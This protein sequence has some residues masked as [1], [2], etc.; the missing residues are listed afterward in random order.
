MP[1]CLRAAVIKALRRVLAVSLI[2]V[3]LSLRHD[4]TG[5]YVDLLL[6]LRG[7][8]RYFISVVKSVK[9]SQGCLTALGYFYFSRFDI[10]YTHIA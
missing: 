9:G 5:T 2:A 8:S 6:I 3:R 7:S 1:G 10:F 4:V